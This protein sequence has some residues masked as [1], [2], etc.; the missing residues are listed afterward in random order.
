MLLVFPEYLS[1]SYDYENTNYFKQ[2]LKEGI[3][4]PS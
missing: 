4:P 2:N 1:V 3:V